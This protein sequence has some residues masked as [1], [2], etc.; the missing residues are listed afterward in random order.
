MISLRVD[1][2][3]VCGPGA[4]RATPPDRANRCGLPVRTD[5]SDSSVLVM[6]PGDQRM[7]YDAPDWLNGTRHRRIFL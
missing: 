3:E 2:Q 6:Q 4:I 7:R 1:G 5:N